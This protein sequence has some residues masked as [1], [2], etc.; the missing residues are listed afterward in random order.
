[1]KKTLLIVAGVFVLLIIIGSFADKK[2]G[3]TENNSTQTTNTTEPTNSSQTQPNTTQ[4][5]EN[6][7]DAEANIPGT[8]LT[9]AYPAKGFYGL[10]AVVKTFQPGDPDAYGH[11]LTI[12]PEQKFDKEK[13]SEFITVIV[14]L[15][16]AG[17]DEKNLKAAVANLGQTSIEQ[18]A[19]KANGHYQTINGHEFFL[20]KVDEE[21]A[22]WRAITLE[23][24]QVLAFTLMYNPNQAKDA[25]T[26]AAANDTLFLEM[27]QHISYK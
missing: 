8:K 18:D 10:G 14:S 4:L 6:R 21:M 13:A 7:F 24:N 11:V 20:F 16:D 2:D 3:S 17:A 12:Q 1:M 27:L 15:A 23:K 25:K 19:I 26:V 9:F 22:F 5:A